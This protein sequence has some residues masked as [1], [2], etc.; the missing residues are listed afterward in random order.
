ML[1]QFNALGLKINVF[2]RLYKN[3]SH[4]KTLNYLGWNKLW[5]VILCLQFS[6]CEKEEL[7]FKNV[8][9]QYPKCFKCTSNR[10]F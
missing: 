6:A 9:F 4:M 1:Q 3:Y 10:R 5:I 8:A 2:K 7:A